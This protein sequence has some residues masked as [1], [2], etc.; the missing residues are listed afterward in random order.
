MFKILSYFPLIRT[1]LEYLPILFLVGGSLPY[2][3]N[4]IITDLYESPP[5][6]SYSPKEEISS[7]TGFLSFSHFPPSK[8]LHSHFNTAPHNSQPN[9]QYSTILS[10]SSLLTAANSHQAPPRFGNIMHP[11]SSSGYSYHR[12]PSHQHHRRRSV[13]PGNWGAPPPANYLDIRHG[14]RFM[15][16]IGIEMRRYVAEAKRRCAFAEGG[17]ENGD[18]GIN[19]SWKVWTHLHAVE[20]ANGCAG[21]LVKTGFGVAG[22]GFGNMLSGYTNCVWLLSLDGYAL[23][24]NLRLL[25]KGVYY[26]IYPRKQ[27]KRKS[28][29]TKY[30]WTW[31]F[32]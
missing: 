17:T 19:G 29:C 2:I 20:F 7:M 21:R 27:R 32:I 30:T 5:W 8:H 1:S 22:V 10:K 26:D 28:L 14:I 23:W 16:G 6:P 18:P 12:P 25:W 3:A 9:L 11:S 13:S 31:A 15:E 4:A 24:K